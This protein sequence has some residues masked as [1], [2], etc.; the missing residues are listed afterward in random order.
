MTARMV[1]SSERTQRHA[2]VEHRPDRASRASETMRHPVD[3]GS[4]GGTDHLLAL[5]GQCRLGSYM[6]ESLLS[7]I[8]N[9]A[10]TPCSPGQSTTSSS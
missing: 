6:P 7:T 8:I 10:K 2:S 5:I 3:S 4:G 1:T 9:L